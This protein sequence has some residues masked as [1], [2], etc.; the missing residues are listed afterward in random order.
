MNADAAL[1]TKSPPPAAKSETH[2]IATGPD[3]ARG[4]G[5]RQSVAEDYLYDDPVQLGSLRAGPDLAD[6]G[7]RDAGRELAVAP[8][9]RAAARRE[10]FRHAAV[11]LSV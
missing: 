9:L 6:V 8:P 1:P 5:V 7:V 3:I 11:P 10:K 2:I 4:W